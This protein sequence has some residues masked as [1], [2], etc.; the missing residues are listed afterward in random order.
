MKRLCTI[1]ARGG[2]KGVLGKNLRDLLGKPLLAHSILQAKASGLFEAVAVNSDSDAILECGLKWGADFALKRPAEM[3]SDTAPKLPAIQWGAKEVERLMGLEFDTFVDLDATSPLRIVKDIVGSVALLE[4]EQASNVL[5]GAPARRSPYFNLVEQD[6]TGRV[7]LSKPPQG[8]VF[9]RQDAPPC[10]D[11]NASIY[12]WDRAHMFGPTSVI[13]ENT[14]L[15]EMPEDRSQD[16][17][18]ELDFEIV[19]LLMK[20]RGGQGGV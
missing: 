18:T 9:R 3:A 1:S 12:V 14:R 17:D 13:L 11:L 20:K 2:S 4:R 7:S 15:F 16:I 10:F 19:E 5:T 6:S 8:A